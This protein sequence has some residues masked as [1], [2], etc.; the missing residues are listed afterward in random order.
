M[1]ISTPATR[2]FT[3]NAGSKCCA[4]SD[5]FSIALCLTVSCNFIIF[6]GWILC[7][8]DTRADAARIRRCTNEPI[9]SIFR[10]AAGPALV[11]SLLRTVG[12]LAGYCCIYTHFRMRRWV[13]DDERCLQSSHV[14][15]GSA[16][17]ISASS[18]SPESYYCI[19]LL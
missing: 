8:L 10:T 7:W 17:Q 16:I 12:Q 2:I 4:V 18:P 13:M 11:C 19:I 14:Y 6:V 1:R 3:S 5:R 15:T 9:F